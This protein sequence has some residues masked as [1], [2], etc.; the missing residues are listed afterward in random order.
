MLTLDG[1][2]S[3]VLKASDTS[4]YKIALPELEEIF[5]LISVNGQFHYAEY[6]MDIDPSTKT[7]FSKLN[8]QTTDDSRLAES[9]MD[10]TKSME[11]FSRVQ[12]QPTLKNTPGIKNPAVMSA[13]QKIEQFMISQD[14]TLSVLFNVI[15]TNSDN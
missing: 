4:D 12:S 14:V 11:Q 1:F 13:R 15:D 2:K 5:N 10:H 6:I 8:L 7:I 3:S 9:S